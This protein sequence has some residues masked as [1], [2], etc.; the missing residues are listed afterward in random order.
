MPNPTSHSYDV[1]KTRRHPDYEEADLPN[2]HADA[3]AANAALR[4]SE[5][6]H[7][8]TVSALIS[9]VVWLAGPD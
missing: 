2:R 8:I 3:D 1:T 9:Q 4:R 6:G 7:E 5:L